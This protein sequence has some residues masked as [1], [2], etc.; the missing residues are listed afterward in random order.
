MNIRKTTT[1]D[2]IPVAKVYRSVSGELET[3][4]RRS[5]EITETYIFSLL[6]KPDDQIVSLVAEDDEGELMGVVHACKN[7]LESYG[8]ILTDLTI[9]VR[10]EFQGKGVA[11]ALGEAILRYVAANRPDVWRL[12]MEARKEKTRLDIF[13]A[14][15]F[16]TEGEIKNR[17][18]NID[19]SFA[20]S[21]LLAW[22][23]PNFEK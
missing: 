11:R 8:H 22:F 9:I 7:G 1:H 15:G 23:N 21:V 10:P 20:D 13:L 14:A 17:I 2:R 5:H 6:N 4:T 3:I 12:E 16:V 18:R 19:G